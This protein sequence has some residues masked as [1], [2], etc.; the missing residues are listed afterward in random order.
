M[1]VVIKSLDLGI[2]KIVFYSYRFI[3]ST[4]RLENEGTRLGDPRQSSMDAASSL[5]GLLEE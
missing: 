3:T 2:V 5:G 4:E 1:T